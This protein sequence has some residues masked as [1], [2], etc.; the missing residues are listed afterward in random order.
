M[1]HL[2]FRSDNRDLVLLLKHKITAGD[3][4]FLTSCD[5]GNEDV[6]LELY[7][8]IFKRQPAEN[9]VCV[10]LEGYDLNPALCK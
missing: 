1:H 2:I 8:H 10:K 7:S 9:A 3:N 4:D 6:A 5:K